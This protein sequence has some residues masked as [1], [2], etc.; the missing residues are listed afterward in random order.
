MNIAMAGVDF[1]RAALEQR[2]AAAF[3]KQ[4]AAAGLQKAVSWP[5]VEGCV[6][7]STCNRTDLWLY[8]ENCDPGRLLCALKDLPYERFSGLLTQRRGDEA[9]RYLFET[10]CGLHSRVW[11]EDQIITQIKDAAGLAMREGTV[12]KVLAK[13]FQAAV[14]AAKEVKTQ[15]RFPH[16]SPSVAAAAVQLC[17][18]A[19][20]LLRACN[21]L[22]IGSGNMG[23][24]AAEKFAAAGANVCITLRR[25]K[26]GI[27][28]LPENCGAVP[29][30]KRMERLGEADIVVSATASPHFTLRAE[31][32]AAVCAAFPRERLFLDLAV[33]RD[34]EPAVAKLPGCTVLT[35]DDI[36][37]CLTAEE[38]ADT[39]RQCRRII[40]R[41]IGEFKK[42]QAARASLPVIEA[43]SGEAASALRNEL[44][45][46]LKPAG[47][48]PEERRR[49][50]DA[51]YAQ[52]FRRV[53]S[54]LFS[55][56]DW[57]EEAESPSA[58]FSNQQIAR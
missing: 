19:R 21:C 52:I 28:P 54:T 15:V 32:T 8:G 31:E 58:G 46:E 47:L 33:P 10:A 3:T 51:A 56:R 34:I 2:E 9:V 39:E 22:V 7:V 37:G 30:E 53:R 35:I 18:N 14:T 17:E 41:H 6:I 49:F 57:T 12:G 45:E 16:G 38:K 13:L 25:Y 27:S 23:C 50:A 24:L 11:G 48:S 55:F 29:F 5:G 20:G 4:Q 36:P 1:E 43:L 26:Y 44:L 40:D 42:W